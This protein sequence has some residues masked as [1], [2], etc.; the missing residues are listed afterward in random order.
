MENITASKKK[1]GLFIGIGV[2]ALVAAVAVLI[3]LLVCGGYKK[4]IDNY[5]DLWYRGEITEETFE[6]LAPAEY[7]EAMEDKFEDYFDEEYEYCEEY[8]KDEREQYEE[9]FGDNYR[10]SY[11]ITDKKE[12]SDKEFKAVK[13]YLRDECDIEKSSVEKAYDVEFDVTVKGSEGE[14]TYEEE[15]MTLIKID[16]KWYL[17][18]YYIEDGV[19]ENLDF[20]Y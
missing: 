4:A 17:C 2:V 1:V 20:G 16:G 15:E 19:V 3:V 12:L 10:V 9:E 6:A 7:W 18:Y 5:V 14:D 13:E 11:E 8:S